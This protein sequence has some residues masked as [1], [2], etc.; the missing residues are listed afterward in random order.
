MS[1]IERYG[2]KSETWVQ[3]LPE[4]VQ[5][6]YSRFV[7]SHAV[8][9]ECSYLKYLSWDL[10]CELRCNTL[11]SSSPFRDFHSN[12]PH[13][14]FG[15]MI[16]SVTEE[17]ESDRDPDYPDALVLRNGAFSFDSPGAAFCALSRVLARACG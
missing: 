6:C 9:A 5:Q 15:Q 13:E 12:D 3:D 1:G 11:A 10:P 14:L 16:N 4:S 17:Y 7:D 8:L 2:A